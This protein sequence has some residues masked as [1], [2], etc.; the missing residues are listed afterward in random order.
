MRLALY[1]TLWARSQGGPV[2]ASV[3]N[4]AAIDDLEWVGIEPDEM[5]APANQK[6]AAEVCQELVASG[7]AYPCYCSMAELRE[8][9]V[10]PLGF[11]EFVHY[12][13]RCRQLGPTDRAAMEKLGRKARIRLIIPEEPVQPADLDAPAPK[14]DF[15]ILE[16]DGS[17]TELFLAILSPREAGAT[18]IL[19]DGA[20]VR[21]LA[22]WLVVADALDWKIPDL[23]ILPPWL[24]AEGEHLSEHPGTWSIAALRDAGFVARAIRIGAARA[25][26]DPGEA[27]DVEA[28]A[29]GFSIDQLSSDSPVADMAALRRLNGEVLARLEPDELTEVMADY[30]ERRGYPFRE[31]DPEWQRRFVRASSGEL[32]T[33]ADAEAWAGIVLTSTVDYDRE[34]ARHLRSPSTHALIAEFQKAMDAHLGDNLGHEPGDWRAVL[35][36]FRASAT[37]PGRALATMRLVL[38]GQR[39]GPGLG[40]I[41][42]LLGR[43]GCQQ[44]LE[45]ARRYTS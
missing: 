10:N 28:M 34:V 30:L 24:D 13:G 36:D 18:A 31:R 44:R 33:L 9:T 2:V 20:R 22:H 11:P 7:R 12:D 40:G 15:T 16:P 38:T 26:W 42:S 25:G 19:V 21:E 17:P 43:D 29:S 6:R 45:K 3:E 32:Q 37:A 14:A 39:E 23:R 35:N 1:G 4:R 5:A 27:T 41:L 8:M